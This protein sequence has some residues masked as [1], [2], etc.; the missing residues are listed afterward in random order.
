MGKRNIEERIKEEA[1]SLVEELQKSK[2]EC[3]L[4]GGEDEMG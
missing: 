2:G 4:G 3:G 1:Q